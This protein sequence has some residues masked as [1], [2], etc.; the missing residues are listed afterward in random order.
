MNTRVYPSEM[1]QRRHEALLAARKRLLERPWVVGPWLDDER[2]FE[3]QAALL[4]YEW[5]CVGFDPQA[6]ELV[7]GPLVWPLKWRM[8]ARSPD[9]DQVMISV[10]ILGSFMRVPV[11][12]RYLGWRPSLPLYEPP[13][14]GMALRERSREVS[15]WCNR[16]ENRLVYG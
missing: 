13:K 11:V 10:R 9:G 14:G 6:V 16:F 15:A 2:A 12:E 7:V 3:E 4:V 1:A 8:H 5:A